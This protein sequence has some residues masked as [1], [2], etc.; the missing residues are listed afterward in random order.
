M[1]KRLHFFVTTSKDAWEKYSVELLL[2][3]GLFLKILVFYNLICHIETTV[4]VIVIFSYGFLYIDRF[5]L[6]YV[7]WTENT[8]NVELT[9]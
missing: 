6:G 1:K 9:F 5:I 3:W 7:N 4:K 8:D 2:V